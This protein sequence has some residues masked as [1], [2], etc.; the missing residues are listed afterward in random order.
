MLGHPD[1][2]RGR[3]YR[4]QR[5]NVK[6]GQAV[7]SRPTRVEEI[8][9]DLDRCRH[10]PRRTRKAGDL[11]DRLTLHS[12]R[13]DEARDLDRRG[14]AAHDRLEGRGCLG[15]TQ[16]FAPDEFGDG[17]DH[18]EGLAAR[19]MKLLRIFLPSLVST[20]SGWNWTPYVGCRTWRRPITVPSFVHAVTTRSSGIDDRSTM[21]E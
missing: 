6:G 11:V 12:Q 18:D 4:R 17:L 1:A 20:D 21:R 13:D 2:A 9:V 14:V 3:H 8:P 15:L 19:L 16:R 10:R 5:G 7:A